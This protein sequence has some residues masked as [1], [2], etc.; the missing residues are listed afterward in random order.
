MPFDFRE[1]MSAPDP[2]QLPLGTFEGVPLVP[3]EIVGPDD[4]IVVMP[5][6]EPPVCGEWSYDDSELEEPRFV[7]KRIDGVAAPTSKATPIHPIRT[8]A[9]PQ[10][11]T[12][13]RHVTRVGTASREALRVAF[14]QS[15]A[16]TVRALAYIAALGKKGDSDLALTAIDVAAA[17]GADAFLLMCA[18]ANAL[19]AKLRYA[20]AEKALKQA[21]KMRP[22]AAE[23][24]LQQ[25]I[26]ACRRGRWRE[27][28]EPLKRGVALAP[29]NATAHYF[30]GEV[31]NHTD[32]LQG[33]L[34]AY[35]RAAELEPDH[36]RAL[37]G[38]GIILDRLGRS[39]DA[40]VFYRRARDAQ[41]A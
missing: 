14:D 13:P 11:A 35:E 1:P 2:E 22:G 21:A 36:W 15:P 27:A 40:A 16:D 23:V 4:E 32:D 20:D 25:G 33:A 38:V 37:K 7:A 3:V 5:V 26:L 34:A 30:A 9:D 19:G 28:V 17:A 8:I 41:R 39:S 31:L 10:G 12:A 24:L 6:R 18:K 29:D